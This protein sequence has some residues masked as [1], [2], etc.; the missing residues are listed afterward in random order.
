MSWLM[1]STETLSII[2]WRGVQ[3]ISKYMQ[4]EVSHKGLCG[5]EGEPVIILSL[6]WTVQTFILTSNFVKQLEASFPAIQI[7]AGLAIT[8]KVFPEDIF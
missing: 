1:Y 4:L 7:G 3:N 6:L 2:Q 8:S 5:S